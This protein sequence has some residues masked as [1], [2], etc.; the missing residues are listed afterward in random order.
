MEVSGNRITSLKQIKYRDYQEFEKFLKNYEGDVTKIDESIIQ[1]Y[2]LSLFYKLSSKQ[3]RQL[4]IEEID[5]LV[6]GVYLA[7]QEELTLNNVLIK[8][9]QIYGLIPNFEKVKSGELI[10]LDNLLLDNNWIALMSVLYRPV[11]GG[12]KG[13]NKRGEY[14]IEPYDEYSET[15]FEDVTAYDVLAVRDFFTKSFHQL[16]QD[17]PT[18]I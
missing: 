10:E 17:S 18:S 11:I 13:I 9:G 4:T 15:L 14:L 6:E 12:R 8:D 7:L 3:Q 5:Y 2:T 16:N 1:F